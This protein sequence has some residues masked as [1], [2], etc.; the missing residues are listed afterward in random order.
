MPSTIYS[1]VFVYNSSKPDS[2]CDM[3]VSQA[4]DV[5]VV[6]STNGMANF[7]SATSGDLLSA[8]QLPGQVFSSPVVVDRKLVVGCRDNFVFC[9]QLK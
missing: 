2:K 5:A 1:T 7:L 6:I 4:G 8:L 3:D 9:Y